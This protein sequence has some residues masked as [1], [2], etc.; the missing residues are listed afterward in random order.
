M[1]GPLVAIVDPYASALAP[2]I[3]ARS[4]R[5]LAVL[6]GETPTAYQGTFRPEDF[7]TV[8]H[9]EGDP[10][11]A[12]LRRLGATHVV[13]GGELGVLLADALREELGLPGNRP[14]PRDARRDKYEMHR[15]VARHGLR[16]PA[17]T[18][19]GDLEEI[20]AWIERNIRLPVVVKPLHSSGSDGVHFCG[21]RSEVRQ[22]F[23]ALIG[24]RNLLGLLNERVLV[25]EFLLGPEYVV[26]TVS[27]AGRHRV[28]AIWRYGRSRAAEGYDFLEILPAEGERQGFLAAYTLAVLEALGIEEGPA[29]SEVMWSGGSPVLIEVGARLHG[30]RTPLL[31]RQFLSRSQLDLAV[32]ALLDPERFLAGQD[33]PYQLTASAAIVFLIPG[34]SGRLRSLPRLDEIRVLPSLRE[35]ETGT[36]PADP[37]PRVA[38][39]LALIHEDPEV[40]TAD[41][42]R[43]REIEDDGLYDFE[44]PA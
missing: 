10:T 24:Q 28:A 35:M 19:S 4:G 8:L 11:V 31:S 30:G 9:Y 32:D 6:S 36:L 1:T 33:R 20:L 5:C 42:R 43:V 13:A 26:D 37:A 15:Q 17:Q 14:V 18:A 41:L 3:S 23:A 21:S 29:H 34:R 39:W 22:A 40:V 16:T 27:H 44:E 38:G 2:E 7:A 25:Q 12:E